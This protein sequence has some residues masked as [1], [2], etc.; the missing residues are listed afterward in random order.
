MNSE[1]VLR[2]NTDKEK[3]NTLSSLLAVVP[4]STRVYWELSINES[5]NLYTKAINYFLELIE[6]NIER[7]NQS[8]IK[9][10]DLSI[11]YLYEYEEQCNMEFQP[12]ELKKLGDSG[13]TLCISCWK[14]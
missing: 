8:G 14:K 5:S 7:L 10:E 6:N 2:I 3:Y 4:T 12:D 13:I 1:Y 11:W 9:K